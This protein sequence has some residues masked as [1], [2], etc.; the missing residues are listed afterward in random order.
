MAWKT[1]QLR[2]HL[3][4]CLFTFFTLTSGLAGHY[5][6]EKD[7]HQNSAPRVF[8]DCRICDHDYIRTEIS[9]V[10]YVRD[11]KEAD[12]HILVTAQRT[13]S[14]GREFTMDFMGLGDSAD[15]H[16]ILRYVSS[17]TDTEEETRKGLV[18]FLKLGLAPFLARTPMGK[19]L[20]LQSSRPPRPTEVA[21][22]WNFWVFNISFN[23]RLSG[24]KT[25][26]SV[27]LS[28]DLAASR[29]T[30]GSKI[31]MNLGFDLDRSHFDYEETEI[32]SQS[33]SRDFSGLFVKS[34][35]EHWSTGGW[36]SLSHS[37][38]RNLG[39]S[40]ALQ[41]ALEYNFFPYSEFTRRQL[42]ALYRI[43]FVFNR[44]LEETIYDKMRERLFM[45]ALLFSFD[46]VEPWGYATLSAEFSHYLHD[47]SKNRLSFFGGL[48]VRL[49]KGLSVELFG[50][51]SGVRD[52]LSLRKGEATLDEILLR[53]KEL[54][55]DYR[56]SLSVGFSYSFGSV[57]SNVVNPRF[58]G[59]RGRRY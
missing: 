57:F 45:E 1:R 22:R 27:S 11:R 52:Q 32:L 31:Q 39:L 47:F 10:N 30:S 34:L 55:S 15:I 41:P 8:L 3:L 49:F 24:E 54:A 51:F 44:Y 37:T 26:S 42:R 21:D 12:I 4:I 18:H 5:F 25:R 9:F 2:I 17:R 59:A 58:G 43:G 53:R 7:L 48:S 6:Q 46:L 35:S 19:S 29:V 36:A 33:E 16:F 23:S 50:N 38:Y 14:G 40:T 13:G 56:Y 28:G 20:D